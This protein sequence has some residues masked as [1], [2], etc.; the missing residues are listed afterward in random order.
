[1]VRSA[2][3]AFSHWVSS[4]SGFSS[5]AFRFASRLARILIPPAGKRCRRHAQLP[6]KRFDILACK[7]PKISAVLRFANYRP[8]LASAAGWESSSRNR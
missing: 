2:T 5:R 7:R 8:F 1:M 6:R 3:S 4:L